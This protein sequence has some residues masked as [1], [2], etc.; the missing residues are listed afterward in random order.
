[1]DLFGTPSGLGSEYNHG[2]D[3]LLV[4]RLQF[5][6][7]ELVG[8]AVVSPRPLLKESLLP[9]TDTMKTALAG[10]QCYEAAISKQRNFV[11]CARHLANKIVRNLH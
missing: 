10:E 2:M 3:P 11:T 1:M 7:H 4:S 5:V 9:L 6:C 8:R